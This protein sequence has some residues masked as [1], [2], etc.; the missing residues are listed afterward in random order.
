MSTVNEDESADQIKW[1]LQKYADVPM[2]LADACLV[3]MS[4][5]NADSPVLTMD[6]DF[7]VYPKNKRQI[8]PILSPSD[9]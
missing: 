4:E 6:D 2:S 7:R 5:M 3:R 1:L 8:I 9:R